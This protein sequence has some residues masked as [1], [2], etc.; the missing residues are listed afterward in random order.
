MAVDLLH[1]IRKGIVIKTSDCLYRD[2]IS[3]SPVV[4]VDHIPIPFIFA[5]NN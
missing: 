3:L 1:L 5:F 2:N 4:F